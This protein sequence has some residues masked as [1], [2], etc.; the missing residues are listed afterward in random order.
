MKRRR[1]AAGLIATGLVVVTLGLATAP[2]EA[3]VQGAVPPS[4]NSTIADRVNSVP[5]VTIWPRTPL[6]VDASGNMYYATLGSNQNY[7]YQVSPSGQSRAMYINSPM[8][9]AGIRSITVGSNNTIYMIVQLVDS[10]GDPQE[11]WYS[12]QPTSGGFNPG[13]MV[14]PSPQ[15]SNVP[16]YA[17]AYDPANGS[18]AVI[19]GSTIQSF[20]LGGDPNARPTVTTVAGNG[21]SGFSGDGGPATQAALNNPRGIAYDQQGN[22]YIADTGNNRIRMVNP[23]GVI[24]TVAGTGVAGY[25][26]DGQPAVDAELNGPSC[27][28]TDA[29]GNVYIADTENNRVRV[30]DDY[31]TIQ[32][33]I[34]SG[35]SGILRPGATA[36]AANLHLP[37]WVGIAGNGAIAFDS[38]TAQYSQKLYAYSANPIPEVT[39]SPSALPTSITSDQTSGYWQRRNSSDSGQPAAF[40]INGLTLTP[41]ADGTKYTS[42]QFTLVSQTSGGSPVTISAQSVSYTVTNPIE[43]SNLLLLNNVTITHVVDGVTY[44]AALPNL[45]FAYQSATGP[46]YLATTPPVPMPWGDLVI[47]NLTDSAGKLAP[48]N[49]QLAGAWV[50]KIDV[51]VQPGFS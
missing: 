42:G 51:T 16:Y 5:E 11:W 47:P 13:Q 29:A 14:W 28:A 17:S 15:G 48:D 6:A 22:L 26:G 24:T 32:T 7:V 49:N 25:A 27:V 45:S 43:F 1:I 9:I 4:A 3:A 18:L 21:T 12:A 41:S 34:G 19:T 30:L 8:S 20:V 2:A 50:M 40:A 46:T 39:V 33:V 35:G 36:P 10:E 38:A 31:R 37:Q 44:R 23:Q